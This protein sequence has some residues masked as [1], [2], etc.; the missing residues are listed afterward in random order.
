MSSS[1]ATS[2]AVLVASTPFPGQKPGTSGL[3]K[4]VDEFFQPN[5]IEN[6]VQSILEA[7][8]GGLRGRTLVVGGDG[9]FGVKEAAARVTR[10][11]A[12]F[13]VSRISAQKCLPQG[14]RWS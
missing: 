1:N 3:R 11:A 14:P 2:E 8:P 5:Y 9:R 12:A 7:A 4:K 10:M 6:F 13:G